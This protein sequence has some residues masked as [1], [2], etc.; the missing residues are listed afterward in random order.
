M[1]NLIK[2]RWRNIRANSVAGTT[3]VEVL[4]AF[5]VLILIMGIFSQAMSLTGRMLGRTEDTL[6]KYR[7][8]AGGYY[9]EKDETVEMTESGLKTMQIKQIVGQTAGSEAFSVQVK[10][11]TYKENDGTGQLVEVV[12]ETTAKAEE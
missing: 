11:R 5:T 7:E 2:K 12:P 3:M 10:T 6:V 4:V 8:L 1:R 9:L